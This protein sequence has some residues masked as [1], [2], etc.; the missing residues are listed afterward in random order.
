LELLSDLRKRYERYE[1][2]ADRLLEMHARGR[3]Y[4]WPI[5]VANEPWADFDDFKV[6]FREAIEIHRRRSFA[7]V[8]MDQLSA[9]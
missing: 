3:V 7:P 1:I 2:P 6:V 5:L 9:R 4:R 8:T